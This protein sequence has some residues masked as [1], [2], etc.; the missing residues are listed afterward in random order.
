MVNDPILLRRILEALLLDDLKQKQQLNLK[1]LLEEMGYPTDIEYDVEERI[2]NYE[3]TPRQLCIWLVQKNSKVAICYYWY[4]LTLKIFT[5]SIYY[6][7]DQNGH[8]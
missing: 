6:L 7:L 1:E 8:S 2:E 5:F 4:I 3:I